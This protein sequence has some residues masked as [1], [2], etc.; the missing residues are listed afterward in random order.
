MKPIRTA[1]ELYACAVCIEREAAERYRE[2]AE[3]MA[4][5]GN[6]DVAEIF[7]RLAVIEGEHLEALL[8]KSRGMALPPVAPE[9]YRWIEAGAPNDAAR[10]L[11]LGLMTSRQALTIALGAELRAEAFFEQVFMTT[12]DAGLRALAREMAGEE[13]EHVV[14]IE[15]LLEGLRAPPL[16]WQETAELLAGLS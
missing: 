2:F 10:E 1:P 8:E 16:D 4:D 14:A 11:V 5:R 13:L 6:D 3:R 12:E 7:A 15:K 9:A